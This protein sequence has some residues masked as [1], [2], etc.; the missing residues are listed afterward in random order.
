MTI[1][2]LSNKKFQFMNFLDFSLCMYDIMFVKAMSSAGYAGKTAASCLHEGG[3]L[4]GV[5]DRA[6]PVTELERNGS[7]ARCGTESVAVA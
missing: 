2:V 7:E 4:S 1:C 6:K 5:S 3:C